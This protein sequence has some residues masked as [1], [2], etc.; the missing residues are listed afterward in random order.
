MEFFC[1]QCQKRH[2]VGDIAADM[3]SICKDDIL[4]GMALLVQRMR[5]QMAKNGMLGDD[6]FDL[7]DSLTSFINKVDDV[8]D[9]ANMESA[10]DQLAAQNS[11]R[12]REQVKACCVIFC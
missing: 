8:V 7:R 6:I 2:P 11:F 5:E 10:E 3:W 4:T 9:M 12:I 1:T